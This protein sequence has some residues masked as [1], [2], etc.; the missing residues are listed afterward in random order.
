MVTDLGK[1]VVQF[2]ISGI[3]ILSLKNVSK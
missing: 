1:V 3:N 2:G